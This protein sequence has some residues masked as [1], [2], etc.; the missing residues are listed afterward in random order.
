MLPVKDLLHGAVH[1]LFPQLCEGCSAPLMKEEEVLCLSCFQELPH[2]GYHLNPDNE[3]AL[4]F[5]GRVPYRHVT[6]FA[7]FVPDSLLQHLLH[8]LKYEQRKEIGLFLG[9]QLGYELQRSNWARDIDGIIPVPLH[10]KKEA[11][12]GY[13]QSMLIATGLAEVLGKEVLS[14]VLKRVKHT[15]TQTQKTREERVV[16]VKDAFDVQAARLKENAHIL[17]IDDVLTT[18][19]TLEAAALTLLQTPGIKVSIATIGIAVS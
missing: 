2:T 8:R 15:Q 17:L 3:A 6:S 18:G 19:A 9:R 1:I 5:A 10:A 7:P 4:R 11:K 13:N 16:N 14:N 12:R